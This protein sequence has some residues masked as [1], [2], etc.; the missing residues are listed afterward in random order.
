MGD[1]RMVELR[2]EY[3]GSGRYRDLDWVDI[4]QNPNLHE[5]EEPEEVPEEEF[6]PEETQDSERLGPPKEAWW[7]PRI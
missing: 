6:L 5:A 2:G 3:F 4:E 1:R 7:R